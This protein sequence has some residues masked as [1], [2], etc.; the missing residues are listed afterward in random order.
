MSAERERRLAP[1]VLQ[2]L[3][4]D[5]WRAVY[6]GEDGAPVADPLVCWALISTPDRDEGHEYGEVLPWSQQA[7]VGLVTGGD[8]EV[9]AAVSI[10]N[11]IAYAGPADDLSIFAERA[12][13]LREE[14]N[15]RGLR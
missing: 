15:E 14:L 8:G 11:F 7:V 13:A 3:P 6:A 12:G 9:D 1:K 10:A 2:L 4:A 5:G